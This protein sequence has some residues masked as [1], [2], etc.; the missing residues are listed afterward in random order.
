M[1]V[2]RRSRLAPFILAVLIVGCTSPTLPSPSASTSTASAEAASSAQADETLR[3]QLAYSAGQDPQIYLLDLETGES[4]QLTELTEEDAELTSE[5]PMRPVLTC[6]FGISSMAWNSRGTH[7]AF[8]YGGCDAVVHVV[9]L[10]GT[11]TRIGDGRGHAWSPDG[12]RLVF[13][14]NTPFCM[15]AADCGDPPHPGAWNLQ[16]ADIGGDGPA[17][18]LMMDEATARAGQPTWSPD[19]TLIAFSGGLQN[20]AANQELFS[21]TYVARS[22]GT[23]ARHVVDGAWPSGWMADGRLLIVDERTG[24]L[25]ALDLETGEAEALGGDQTGP[26]VISPD[27]TRILTSLT[28]PDT[29]MSG[30]QLATI[31]GEAL[32]QRAGFPGGWA[33]DARAAAIVDLEQAGGLV[34]LDRDGNELRTYVL[35]DAVT[36]MPVVAWKPGS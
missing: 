24:I 15:G 2:M 31:E 8:T 3:G 35:P 18:P 11:T 33:P 32:V 27:G 1:A 5:G 7:L 13:A 16:V 28:D 20:L 4:V 21:A 29:G 34:I 30:V 26:T 19:G 9:D 17:V 25:H 23:D 22:D 14:A 6:G 12:A 10:E 36:M